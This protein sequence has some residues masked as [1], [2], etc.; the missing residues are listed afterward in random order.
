MRIFRENPRNE[1]VLSKTE[2]IISKTIIFEVIDSHRC[3]CRHKVG[4]RF[5]YDGTGALITKL[6]PK[7]ICAF[8]LNTLSAP[9]F[10]VTEFI[11]AGIDPNRIRF[12]EIGCP[13]V[14]VR[15]GGWGHIVMKL[16]VED[17]KK[18]WV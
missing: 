7:K 15:C 5:V 1:E 8:V 10:T 6:N 12:R 9:V 18:S 2:D 16:K 13:D 4:D 17:R 3:N 14:G 11:Y